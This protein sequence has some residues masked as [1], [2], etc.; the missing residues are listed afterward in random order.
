MGNGVRAFDGSYGSTEKA[1]VDLPNTT[2]G[3]GGGV[4]LNWEGHEK[5]RANVVGEALKRFPR[6]RCLRRTAGSPQ[7][8]GV[9]TLFWRRGGDRSVS[10]RVMVTC[11]NSSVSPSSGGGAVSLWDQVS[12]RESRPNCG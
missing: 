10:A 12:D 2:F 4:L 8:P 6:V 11:L 5:E 3:N 9:P 7:D 1:P